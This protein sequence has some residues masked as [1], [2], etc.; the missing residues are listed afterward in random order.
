[1]LDVVRKLRDL[2]AK[3]V[4]GLMNCRLWMDFNGCGFYVGLRLKI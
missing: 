4:Y 3:K 1:L 2:M